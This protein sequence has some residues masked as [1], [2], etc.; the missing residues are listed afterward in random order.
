MDNKKL[1]VALSSLFMEEFTK[2]I[3]MQVKT[4]NERE[5]ERKTII[6]DTEPIRKEVDKKDSFLMD[7]YTSDIMDAYEESRNDWD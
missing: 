6:K 5:N 4:M 2:Y 7:C 1:L 3:Y